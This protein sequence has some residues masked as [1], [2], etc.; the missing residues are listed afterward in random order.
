[1]STPRKRRRLSLVSTF[2]YSSPTSKSKS[3]PSDSPSN[4]FGTYRS[5]IP[6]LPEVTSFGKHLPLRFHVVSPYEHDRDNAFRVVQV[7]L[8]YSLGLVATTLFW[9]FG[10][11]P[12]IPV[13]RKTRY[14]RREVPPVN[15]VR[16][17]GQDTRNCRWEILD[18]V[19]TDEGVIKS[20]RT[21][22][23]VMLPF[24]NDEDEDEAEEDVERLLW[25]EESDITLH[26]AW[27]KG[28]DFT[29]GLIFVSSLTFIGLSYLCHVHRQHHT[30]TTKVHITVNTLPLPPKRGFSN[31][32]FVFQGC[33]AV[34]L[35]RP[36]MPMPGTSDIR[37]IRAEGEDAFGTPDDEDENEGRGKKDDPTLV[38]KPERWKWNHYR[39]FDRYHEKECDRM[40]KRLVFDH[41][42]ELESSEADS[43]SGD[44]DL[45]IVRFLHCWPSLFIHPWLLSN[46]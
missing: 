32:P 12:E 15:N 43:S 38:L 16:V 25:E 2:S 27:P 3:T 28:G 21:W 24:V 41:D 44:V 5:H 13:E 7:P 31:T 36:R 42:G 11:H 20:G 26:H 23:R 9:I 6:C 30:A 29:R 34:Y 45:D 8:N 33:G 1:M 35:R 10:G 4:P 46:E 39:V 17:R 19:K 40:I 22:S 14:R 18:G 37:M